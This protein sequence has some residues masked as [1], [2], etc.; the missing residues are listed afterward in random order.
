MIHSDQGTV[1]KEE[2]WIHLR[3]IYAKG[4]HTVLPLKSSTLC[5][6]KKRHFQL[7]SV[8]GE[9]MRFDRIFDR[10]LLPV[11]TINV[12]LCGRVLHTIVK[13]SEYI[14]S[15]FLSHSVITYSRNDA[16]PSSQVRWCGFEDGEPVSA[17]PPLR[18]SMIYASAVIWIATKSVAGVPL[19]NVSM[20]AKHLHLLN[21]WIFT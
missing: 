10:G 11:F 4:K 16:S 2:I 17:H 19:T 21:T 5:N 6:C 13:L 3:D 1:V 14:D 20:L 15:T 12:P 8:L 7:H 9:E 18:A